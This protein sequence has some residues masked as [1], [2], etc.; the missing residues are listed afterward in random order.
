VTNDVLSDVALLNVFDFY[1]YE[2]K[3]KAWHTLVHVCQ[4]WR[5]VAFGSPR[6]LNLRLECTAR[7]PVRKMLKIW[8]LLPIVVVFNGIGQGR[9]HNWAENIIAALEHHDRI[10]Q[11]NF[12]FVGSQFEQVSEAMLQPFQELTCLQ[13]KAYFTSIPDSFLGGSAPRL[14]T[15]ILEGV[16]FPELPNLLLS[17]THL[18]HLSLLRIS[19][20]FS[21]EAMTTCLSVLPKLESLVMDFT[22]SFTGTRNQES[23]QPSLQTHT[24]L[25]V[26]RELRFT[27]IVGYL[28]EI[29]A[30]IDAPLL[31]KLATKLYLNQ[32]H[33]PQITQ[34]ISRTPI[35]KAHDEARVVFS[36]NVSVT[37]DGALE[38]VIIAEQVHQLWFL[39]EACN[40]SF[41][42]TLIPA[43]EHLYIQDGRSWSWPDHRATNDEWLRFLR[44]FTAVRSFYI[45]SELMPSIAATLQ[46]LVGERVSEVLP[47]LQTLFL[48]EILRSDP[49]QGAIG[50]FVAARQLS[51]HPV[52][53]SRWGKRSCR[54]RPMNKGE[55]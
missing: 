46:E 8:P 35:F 24:H 50:K 15:L 23:R 52:T 53:V 1:M 36:R 44:T 16:S 18:V 13:L 45:S 2:E 43:V 34:F 30:Q 31:D 19:G 55:D 11:I 9:G 27:G 39:G 4:Q 33:T 20:L 42:Q 32:F 12:C 37:L 47:A 7:T 26:L 21:F 29:A 38:F 28:E 17:S 6:R 54:L 3:I 49:V 41:L 10:C 40:S 51:S 25:P 22:G 48:E 14:Q 5:N